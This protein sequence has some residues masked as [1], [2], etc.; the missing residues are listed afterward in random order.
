MT[1][2]EFN[3]APVPEAA[4]P[5]VEESVEDVN[6]M[7]DALTDTTPDTETTQTIEDVNEEFERLTNDANNTTTEST[8][9]PDTTETVPDDIVEA[10]NT[11]LPTNSMTTLETDTTSRFR[12][13]MWFSEVSK[14]K[15][16]II[17]QGGIGSW[18][19]LIVSR[20]GIQYL[21]TFD[22]DT[23]E[24]VNMAGQLFGRNHIGNKKATAVYHTVY[25]L[26]GYFGYNATSRNFVS[27]DFLESI[28]IGALDNMGARKEVF[29]SWYR[30]YKG[31]SAALLIDGRLSADEFQIFVMSGTDEARI[32][33]YK[34]K[35]LF[36]DAE[37][38]HTLCSFKQTTYMASMI[39]SYIANVI[40]NH[41]T[42][43]TNPDAM[44]DLPFYINYNAEMM[45]LKTVNI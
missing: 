16:S 8:E 24:A 37:G 32:K 6:D 30:R 28:T 34:S 42:N 9:T 2:F 17:G 25:D 35:W 3:L 44:F 13:A 18:T 26:C 10:I 33:E 29:N 4:T 39:A 20:L 11:E 31:V 36:D 22:G 7:F 41:C 40:V 23:V 5:V 1:D 38:E 14:S 15:V 45:Y 12:G 19:S 27:T 21:S 43:L